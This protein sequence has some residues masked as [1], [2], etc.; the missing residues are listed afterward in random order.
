MK[1]K[2][3]LRNFFHT[4]LSH[5]SISGN[6]SL[7]EEIIH[8]ASKNSIREPIE[9][10]VT[11]KR[12]EL[13]RILK[14]IDNSPLKDETEAWL[15]AAELAQ[16]GLGDKDRLSELMKS[17]A[18]SYPSRQRTDLEN[19]VSKE[20][21][22]YKVTIR[23]LPFLDQS[24][25]KQLSSGWNYQR[26]LAEFLV[27]EMGKIS[28]LAAS[29]PRQAE[30][31]EERSSTFS[32]TSHSHQNGSGVKMTIR[33]IKGAGSRFNPIY[34][35]QIIKKNPER[36]L[37]QKKGRTWEVE[38]TEQNYRN[39]GL[40]NMP[41]EGSNILRTPI[42]NGNN[43]TVGNGT[44]GWMT[45]PEIIRAGSVLKYHVLSYRLKKERDNGHIRKREGALGNPWEIEV[46]SE[47][48]ANLGLPSTFN[49]PPREQHSPTSSPGMDDQ[50]ISTPA[51]LP[52]VSPRV[53]IEVG[54]E[55][56]FFSSSSSYRAD[57]IEEL[58]LKMHSGVFND[59]RIRQQVRAELKVDNGKISGEH[60]VPFL[61]KVNGILLLSSSGVR[62]HLE[63]KLGDNSYLDEFISSEQAQPYV[64][65]F[66]PIIPS[67]YLRKEDLDLF[68]Q[69]Y[70]SFRRLRGL[71]EA[72]AN[73]E[74][75]RGQPSNTL[76]K[77]E[78]SS[79]TIADSYLRN[80]RASG[81]LNSRF[82]SDLNERGIFDLTTPENTHRS[83]RRFEQFMAGWEYFDFH[84]LMQSLRGREVTWKHIET[85][86]LVNLTRQGLVKDIAR[87]GN[88]PLYVIKE[89]SREEVRRYITQSIV[90]EMSSPLSI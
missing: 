36:Y 71:K 70:A 41:S 55:K 49:I 37:A 44:A 47:N 20:E 86:Q 33:E 9:E 6:N 58:L 17:Q 26:R 72:V 21:V 34:L 48:L 66:P 32:E 64:H 3:P 63:T 85:T 40:L 90:N 39:L 73:A 38:V 7:L 69:A 27:A 57:K 43:H 4:L 2:T 60:L 81:V 53:H 75:Y 23:S 83:F 16:Y 88:R 79:R 18:H 30:D 29:L 50:Q 31:L 45:I 13:R 11:I 74:S 52:D 42:N 62:R 61:K 1:G 24:P 67:A 35:S 68:A 8:A 14:D 51:L 46:T 89:G 56:Y 78:T 25:L 84:S 28:S 12:N 65:T 87:G 5:P 15:T 10:V 22:E 82:E 19:G 76:P 77:E 59:E 80:L 54:G